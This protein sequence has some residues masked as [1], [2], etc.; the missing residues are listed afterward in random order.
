MGPLA[1]QEPQ[2]KKQASPTWGQ[3]LQGAEEVGV[4]EFRGGV[5]QARPHRWAESRQSLRGGTEA[6]RWAS[7]LGSRGAR[8]PPFQRWL[9][10]FTHPLPPAKSMAQCLS[11]GLSSPSAWDAGPKKTN[12]P[13]ICKASVSGEKADNK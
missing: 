1:L 11:G 7:S 9:N 3:D 2:R 10:S 5:P 12:R 8:V 13:Q 6:E 4:T